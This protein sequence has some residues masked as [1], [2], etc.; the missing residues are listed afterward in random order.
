M[1]Q[2]RHGRYGLL[3]E[4]DPGRKPHTGDFNRTL[5][6]RSV[7]FADWNYWFD[8]VSASA[9]INEPSHSDSSISCPTASWVTALISLFKLG[10]WPSSVFQSRLHSTPRTSDLDRPRPYCVLLSL[11]PQL[12]AAQLR[13]F[14]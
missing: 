13:V 3:Q 7:L 10:K 5:V 12:G 1:Q 11:L 2:A 4:G 9:P 8:R 6:L 14:V